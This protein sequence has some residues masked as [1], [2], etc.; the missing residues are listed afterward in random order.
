MLIRSEDTLPNKV[1][2]MKPNCAEGEDWDQHG[3]VRLG[4]MSYKKEGREW[5]ETGGEEPW[6]DS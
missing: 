5:E 4:N 1:L 2:I 6:E 3:N